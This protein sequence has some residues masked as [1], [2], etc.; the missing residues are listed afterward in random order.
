MSELEVRIERLESMRVAYVSGFGKSPEEEA[1]NTILAWAK[2][3]GLL[4]NLKAIRF[5]GFDNPSPSP[6]SP[7]Y[8]YEQW[9]TVGPDVEPAGKVQI[10]EFSGGLYAVASCKGISNIG[11]VWKQLLAWQKNSR[12]K[13]ASHQCLEECLTPPDTPLDDVLM[14][15]YLPIAE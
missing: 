12:Y 4:D 14:D 9:I 6:G 5:F 11:P 8:G 3:K 2:S 7:N 10:K 13:H 15:L 1:W